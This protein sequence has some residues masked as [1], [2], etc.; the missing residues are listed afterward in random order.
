[1]ARALLVYRHP[2]HPLPLPL[3]QVPLAYIHQV[4]VTPI[5]IR[6]G[7]FDRNGH[8]NGKRSSLVG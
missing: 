8:E 2:P 1:M 5:K 6:T 4:L 3:L 7:N